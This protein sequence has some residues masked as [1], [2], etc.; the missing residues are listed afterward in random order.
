MPKKADVIDLFKRTS[1]AWA[2]GVGKTM[3]AYPKVNREILLASGEYWRAYLKR[4]SDIDISKGKP[5]DVTKKYFEDCLNEGY[6]HEEDK[7]SGNDDEIKIT[8]HSCFY[9]PLCLDL[10]S[11]G[12]PVMCVRLGLLES[13]IQTG[14]DLEYEKIILKL[15][16]DHCE[17]ILVP[18]EKMI[19]I[20]AEELLIGS[21]ESE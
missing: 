6:M 9:R 20:E 10:E 15:D 21:W 7:I 13:V 8:H 14:S 1:L 2:Y 12:I 3:A 19:D 4:K 17:G 16:E 18:K 5:F 11:R